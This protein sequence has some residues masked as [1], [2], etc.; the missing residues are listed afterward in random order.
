MQG[1]LYLFDFATLNKET[2]SSSKTTAWNNK[3][4][5]RKLVNQ[6]AFYSK[7]ILGLKKK[8]LVIS[9]SDL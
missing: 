9:C 5:G 1:A 8:N 4:K 2:A 3:K 7:Q 6:S